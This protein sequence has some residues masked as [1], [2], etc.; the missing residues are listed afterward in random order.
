[1]KKILI[2]TIQTALLWA[3]TVVI[4]HAWKLHVNS[5]LD[6]SLAPRLLLRVKGLL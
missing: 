6:P 2:M 4:L 3:A 5:G 1:M